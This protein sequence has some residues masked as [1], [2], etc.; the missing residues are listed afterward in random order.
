MSHTSR[1]ISAGST[2]IGSQGNSGQDIS[3]GIEENSPIPANGTECLKRRLSFSD[4][5]SDHEIIFTRQAN[6]RK[7]MGIDDELKVWFAKELEKLST[8]EQV[9]GLRN[10][11]AS[12]SAKTDENTRELAS[13]RAQIKGCLLYTS[14][15]PRDGLLSRMPSSA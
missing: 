15:S 12:N 7:K 14:T 8:K 2:P 11:I 9:D 5:D 3:I 10:E 4:S 1:R 13:V 6:K